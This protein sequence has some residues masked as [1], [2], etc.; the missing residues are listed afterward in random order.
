MVKL[1]ASTKAQ[2][3]I[4]LPFLVLPDPFYFF[5]VAQP[6]TVDTTAE[7][8]YS[9]DTLHLFAWLD[10]APSGRIV[11]RVDYEDGK[12]AEHSLELLPADEASS[13]QISLPRLAVNAR[14]ESLNKREVQ[15]LAVEYQLITDQ[16]SCVLVFDRAHPRG[17]AGFRRFRG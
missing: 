7:G 1:A 17:T 9:G 12:Q 2:A 16:T 11:L 13:F 8:V 3:K 6:L 4:R 5:A 14:L 15:S 10:A